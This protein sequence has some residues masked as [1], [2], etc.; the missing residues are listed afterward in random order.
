MQH[1]KTTRY[2][3]VVCSNNN[4][5]HHEGDI[6][7]AFAGVVSKNPHKR[8]ELKGGGGFHSHRSHDF[9]Q[10][11]RFGSSPGSIKVIGSQTVRLRLNAN[12]TAFIAFLRVTSVFL[13]GDISR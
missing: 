3:D 11:Q 13:H 12:L 6:L 1:R 2:S 4:N 8:W 7:I 5:Q 9:L 10:K